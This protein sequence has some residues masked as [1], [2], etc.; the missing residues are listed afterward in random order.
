MFIIPFTPIEPSGPAMSRLTPQISKLLTLDQALNE[1]VGTLSEDQRQVQV[2]Q[3]AQASNLIQQV[4][5]HPLQYEDPRSEA[6]SGVKTA[7][8]LIV[9]GPVTRSGL[10]LFHEMAFEQGTPEHALCSQDPLPGQLR[11]QRIKVAHHIAPEPLEVASLLNKWDQ[12]YAQPNASLI[13]VLAGHHRLCWIHPFADGNGRAARFQLY[14]GLQA[15][16]LAHAWS[17]SSALLND[18]ARY[19][20]ALSKADQLRK[21]AYD[22]RG[23][24]SEVGLVD[25]A[26]LMTGA[27]IAEIERTLAL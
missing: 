4:V 6:P 22:G 14:R 12:F 25:Y 24:L 11:Q 1:A 18:I 16:G 15:L 21:G 27:F 17:P 13:Q 8:D 10:M 23:R 20:Q 5:L 26:D 19:W 3:E 2:A 7:L 9:P